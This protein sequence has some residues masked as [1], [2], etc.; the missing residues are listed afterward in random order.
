MFTTEG[1]PSK[2]LNQPNKKRTSTHT[3]TH[4]IFPA[5]WWRSGVARLKVVGSARRRDSKRKPSPGIKMQD[6][7]IPII[8]L[9]VHSAAFHKH[10]GFFFF[11]HHFSLPQFFLSPS[12]PV[13][14][15]GG[16]GFKPET[17]SWQQICFFFVFVFFKEAPAGLFF[18]SISLKRGGAAG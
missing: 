1:K 17:R 11:F 16:W 8:P 10:R 2:S 9:K 12:P 5:P 4:T 13:S 6:N 3:H 14:A 18:F 15:P 7:R